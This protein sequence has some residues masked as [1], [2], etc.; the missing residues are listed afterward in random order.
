VESFFVTE[1]VRPDRA[2]ITMK[3]GKIDLDLSCGEVTYE[4]IDGAARITLKSREL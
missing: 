1:P 2:P 3:V 4:T